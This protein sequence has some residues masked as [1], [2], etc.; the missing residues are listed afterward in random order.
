MTRLAILVFHTLLKL[1]PR[2]FRAEFEA[3]MQTVFQPHFVEPGH[4][5]DAG[6]IHADCYIYF[7]ASSPTPGTAKTSQLIP[8]F[9]QFFVPFSPH[10]R[11]FSLICRCLA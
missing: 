7:V 10:L 8:F 1:Y 9:L 4:V 6:C 5:V 11:P 3:E 2:H